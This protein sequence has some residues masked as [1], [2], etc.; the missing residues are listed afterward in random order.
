M[1]IVLAIAK[2]VVVGRTRSNKMTAIRGL[3]PVRRVTLLKNV[4]YLRNL[5]RTLGLDV[6]SYSN[7]A[8][9]DA[10][11]TVSLVMDDEWPSDAQ[12]HEAFKRLNMPK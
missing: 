2:Q 3:V 10:M 8:L 4:A 1:W 5:F 11:L 9:V 7:A 6:T 12:I